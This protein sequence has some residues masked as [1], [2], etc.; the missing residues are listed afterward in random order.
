MKSIMGWANANPQ[1]AKDHAAMQATA[2]ARGVS[3]YQIFVD[4]YREWHGRDPGDNDIEPDFGRYLRSGVVPEVVRHYLRLYKERHPEQLASYRREGIV[5]LAHARHTE[6]M[7]NKQL[8]YHGYRFPSQIISHAVWLYYR[9]CLSVRAVKDLLAE[10]GITVSYESI[11]QWCLQFGPE[12]ARRL[13]R[14]RGR[15]G[16]TGYLDEVF[17]TIRG[18][19]YYLWRAVDQ[20]GDV[21]DILVQR[22]RDR[23]AAKRFFRKLLKGQG[24]VPRKIVTDKLR[25]YGAARRIVLPSV[26]H[27]TEQYENNRAEV[28]HQ[29]TRQRE[30]HMRRFKSASQAQRFLTIHGAVQN[31]FRVGRHLIRASHGRCFRARAFV[32]WQQVT[33]A[34]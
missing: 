30:R 31:L 21:I 14:R 2:A 23:D 24:A 28:S 1:S 15:L 16:D 25:S 22:R 12:Y 33:C 6:R 18:E 29:P 9:F 20:D 32:E 4:A 10:R 34:L 17:I 8:S 5:K 19:R 26:I 7:T 3:E 27:S 13:K 11:R